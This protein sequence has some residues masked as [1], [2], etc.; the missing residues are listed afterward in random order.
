MS[1]RI[2]KILVAI[3]DVDQTPRALLRQAASIARAAKASV[4]LFHA[5]E[6]PLVVGFTPGLTPEQ[7]E[8]ATSAGVIIGILV[9]MTVALTAVTALIV[10]LTRKGYNWARIVLGAMGVYIVVDMVFS[11]FADISPAWA[12]VPLVIGGVAALGATVLLMKGDSEKYCR[13]MAQVRKA[14]KTPQPAPAVHGP[15]PYAQNPYTQNP[16]AQNPYTQNPY[17][18]SPY[19]Q[20]PYHENPYGQNPHTPNPAANDPGRPHGSASQSPPEHGGTP[21]GGSRSGDATSADPTQSPAQGPGSQPTGTENTD[22][23]GPNKQ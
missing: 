9:A 8:T 22:T 23:E 11:F 15:N 16:Y 13:R 12:M 17:G 21:Y 1:V 20:N 19:E 10:W 18:Q 3:R 14:A 6:D 7:L 2:K 5:I 4:E